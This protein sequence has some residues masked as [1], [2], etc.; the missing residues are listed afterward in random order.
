[1][2]RRNT[3][4]F[5][6]CYVTNICKA[7]QLGRKVWPFGVRPFSFSWTTKLQKVLVIGVSTQIIVCYT[8]RSTLIDSLK[9]YTNTNYR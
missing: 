5:I 2:M 4:T 9:Y 8:I 3:C 6:F 7:S 1:M